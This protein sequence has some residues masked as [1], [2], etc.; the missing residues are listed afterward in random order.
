MKKSLYGL[1]ALVIIGGGFGFYRYQQATSA[2]A[3][4]TPENLTAMR[5]ETA[6][7][8]EAAFSAPAPQGGVQQ[9]AD[10]N[11]NLYFG[12]LHVHTSLSFDSYLFGNRNTLD[13]AYAFARGEPLLTMA[14]ERMQ[15]SRPL[16]FVGITDHAETFGMMDAC[17]NETDLPPELQEFCSGLDNP[18]LG[19]F[20]KLRAMGVERPPKVP[21]FI[22]ELSE[23]DCAAEARE[24]GRPM[25]EMIKDRAEHNNKPGTFTAFAAYEYS[26]PLPERGKH[27]RNIFFR[28]EKT[29]TYAYSAFDARTAPIL[30]KML[31]DDCS[32]DCEFL[33]IPHNMNKTWGL[34]YAQQTIDG[35]PY[36]DEDWARRA[37][38][39][40]LA[41]MYQVKG[42]SECATGQA[43]TD[44]ECAFEQF[45]PLCEGGETIGCITP[46]SMVR[47]GLKL[48]LQME[49]SEGINPFQVGFIGSTDTHNGNP[50]DTEEYD[51]RGAT[52]VFSSPA[53][54][55][56]SA[57]T[58]R[59]PPALKNPGG[60]AA[61]W[62]IENTRD[63]L[64]DS[65][66]QR[67]AYAT[68]GTRIR[69]RFFAGEGYTEAMLNAP[70]GIEQAYA[71]GVPMGGTLSLTAGA[72]P[73][74]LMVAEMDAMSVP[75]DR[76]QVIKGWVVNGE[77][78]EKVMDIACSDG[79][80]PD[81]EGRCQD[82]SAPVDLSN[83]A[84]GIDKGAEQ[85][86]TVWSDPDY[87][88]SV[89]AF[90]YLR[91]LEIPTCRWTTYDALR[92]GQAPDESLPATHRERAWSS[93][94]WVE[95]TGR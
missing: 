91:V 89:K 35:D 18:S 66:Q 78:H 34:A 76:V 54:R 71:T 30:W 72:S 22:C 55:R 84:P 49:S 8:N 48:G 75:L 67:E 79:R 85:L 4:L 2:F 70:D 62:A 64:F 21:D 25:W 17:I 65:M 16:D 20:L 39:E 40:P 80:L 29:S 74:F 86:S 36:T 10:R 95:A 52:G 63:A 77:S 81:A 88:P 44:E 45:F 13:Q 57:D 87:D 68:S 37:R 50:G 69:L 83:C 90:Y 6:A 42:A 5:A 94:V 26:P 15:L 12:D 53:S 33:T 56:L 47:D 19:F 3:A 73:G 58:G 59:S 14:G 92:V 38:Y 43:T 24:M 27:H 60:L 31:E 32:G 11:K 23:G 1:I 41:E 61:V 7:Q 51:F 9:K 46:T 82:L 28:N 93:P